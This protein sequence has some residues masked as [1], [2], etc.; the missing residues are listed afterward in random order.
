EDV[1]HWIDNGALRRFFTERNE[2]PPGDVLAALQEYPELG[3]LLKPVTE[4]LVQGLNHRLRTE[5][6]EAALAWLNSATNEF[7]A[8]T[9]TEGSE[10]ARD[11]L[12]SVAVPATD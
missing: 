3:E 6:P 1:Q 2:A 10:A 7:S 8:R 12:R 5:G 9:Q 11:W 4:L